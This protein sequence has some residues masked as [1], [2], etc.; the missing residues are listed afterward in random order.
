MLVWGESAVEAMRNL[1]SQ[2]KLNSIHSLNEPIH[3]LLYTDTNGK[4]SVEDGAYI[5]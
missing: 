1:N 2:P 4:T 5:S 3:L